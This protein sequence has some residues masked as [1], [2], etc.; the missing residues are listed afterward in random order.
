M[1][2]M[3][4]LRI[5]FEKE[6]SHGQV[7]LGIQHV[8][9]DKCSSSCFLSLHCHLVTLK[10]LRHRGG[11]LQCTPGNRGLHPDYGGLEDMEHS[12]CGFAKK[13]RRQSCNLIRPVAGGLDPA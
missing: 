2:A 1:P 7:I 6:A 10:N 13:S 5:F 9:H 3:D 8:F 11:V 4:A 12:L